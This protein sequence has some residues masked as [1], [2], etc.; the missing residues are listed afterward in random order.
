[1]VY[2]LVGLLQPAKDEPANTLLYTDEAIYQVVGATPALDERLHWLSHQAPPAQ[3]KVWGHWVAAVGSA[4]QLVVTGL[5]LLNAAQAAN[6]ALAVGAAASVNVR[7]RPEPNAPTVGQISQGEGYRIVGRDAANQWWLICCIDGE[8]AWV[9][10]LLVTVEGTPAAVPVVTAAGV[11]AMTT[12]AVTVPVTASVATPIAPPIVI[13]APGSPLIA[14]PTVVAPTPV[15]TITPVVAGVATT[16]L[17]T[18]TYFAGTAL[19]GQPVATALVPAVNFDWGSGAPVPQ[20]PADSFSARYE[21]TVPLAP[22]FYVLRAQADDGVRVYVNDEL[23]IDEWHAAEP[24][25]YR[26]GRQ[27]SGPTTFR[28]EYYESG[29]Q[30][31]LQFDYTLVNEFPAWR[32]AYFDNITLTGPPAWVQ[33][34][35]LA[36]DAA[37][38]EQW[39]LGSPV[40]G[41]I[42]TD[43]WSARWTGSFP[44]VG[45]NYIF[46][47]DANDGIRVWIDDILVIDKWQDGSNHAETV[48]DAIGPGRHA[49]T[50]EYYERGGLA[51]V[52][53]E[54]DRIVQ[55]E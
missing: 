38:N 37:L 55:P 30:A 40:P 53:V 34:E 36:A 42:P 5:L 48:F 16:A 28:V 32:A 23:V 4:R 26:A 39:S 17:W 45:G 1:M 7:S 51:N 10:Q 19:A 25:A 6:H 49:I 11:I 35:P 9:Q 13:T 20:L 29:G 18:A 50:V 27:L 14:T 15:V 31:A 21:Q 44:F 52:R 3:V 22:G 47:A 2:G 24:P 8:T 12:P 33:P 43:N 54:W 41:V 46:R